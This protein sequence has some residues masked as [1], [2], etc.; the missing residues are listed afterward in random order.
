MSRVS[1]FP[2]LSYRKNPRQSGKLLL[3]CYYEHRGISTVPHNIAYL[4]SLSGYEID[5]F[6]FFGCAYPLALPASFELSEYVGVILHNSLTYNPESLLSLDTNLRT[7]FADYRGLKIIFEQDEQVK[8]QQTAKYIGDNKFDL[9]FTCLPES[10]RDK[11]YPPH[12]VGPVR[13]YQ[14]LTGY[15]TPEL[16]EDLAGEFGGA[17]TIDVGYRGSLQPAEFGMLCFEK[18]TIGTD[19]ENKTRDSGLSLDIS[20]RWEDRFVGDDWFRFLCRCKAVLGVESGASIFDLDG[21]VSLKAEAYRR[22]HAGSDSDT[23]YASNLLDEL[24]EYEGNV[25]YNQIS[26]RHFEAAATKT[27]QI[28]F[29]GEYSGLLAPWRHYVPLKRDFSNVGEVLAVL[30]DEDTRRKIVETAYHDIIERTDLHIERFV[31]TFDKLVDDMHE[32]VSWAV[33]PARIPALDPTLCNVLLLCAHVPKLDPRV[34]WIQQRGPENLAIHVIG[35]GDAT[36]REPVVAGDARHGYTI[37]VPY[38]DM[39]RRDWQR[40]ESESNGVVPGLE[41][42]LFLEWFAALN[43]A[44][45]AH[46]FGM[47][48][49]AALNSNPGLLAA[50]FLNTAQQLIDCGSR[51]TGINAVIACDLDTLIAGA[52]L[53]HVLAVP[54]IYDAHEFWPDSIDAFVA[55]DFDFWQTVERKLVRHVDHAITV[56]TGIADFMSS[57]Y[58][59]PFAYLPNCEPRG[60]LDLLSNDKSGCSKYRIEL[61]P[62][63]VSFLVQGIFARGRGYETIIDA[64]SD[65]SPH[66]VLMLRGP[67]GQE[68]DRLMAYALKKG[69]PPSRIV[70][71]EPVSERELVAAASVAD[72]GVIPYEPKSINNRHCGPNKLSQYMAAGIPVLANDLTFVRSILETGQCGLA[73]DFTN[74]RRFVHTV[75]RLVDEHAWRQQMGARGRAYFLSQFNWDVMSVD[76]YQRVISLAKPIEFGAQIAKSVVLRPGIPVC[77]DRNAVSDA[78]ATAVTPAADAV[79]LSVAVPRRSVAYHTARLGWRLIPGPV[80]LRT[81]GAVR[82]ILAKASRIVG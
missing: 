27:L 5:V 6:N 59:K 17:R 31:E 12:I 67:R 29:E 33:P 78:P 26:P 3:L 50:Y 74:R 47:A 51:F 60:I 56:T 19:F 63:D 48:S 1:G 22:A 13:F 38:R 70:F 52:L 35:V 36:L 62:G 55:S 73:I 4:Q 57:Y 28:L 30:G 43:A 8:P 61:K 20:S 21:T 82:R 49:A 23:E 15:V 76:F 11:V 81:I 77:G 37:T 16:R 32:K 42:A 54:L 46:T 72:V 64:W 69:L 7:S 18:R 41:E 44:D 14:M 10:E 40:F 45:R 53:K 2:Q 80:R 79:S 24:A 68:R 34:E 65:V 58:G 66:A 25:R 71:P 75:N 9:I 39:P